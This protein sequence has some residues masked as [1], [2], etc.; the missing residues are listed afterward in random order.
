MPWLS[1]R[2]TDSELYIWMYTIPISTAASRNATYDLS[3][4]T[5]R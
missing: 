4:N 1:R 5:I 3:R 2:Y